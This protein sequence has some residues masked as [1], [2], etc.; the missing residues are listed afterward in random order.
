MRCVIAGG[1]TGGHLFPGIAIAEAFVEK[2]LGNEVL[3][4]GTEKGIEARVL[5]GGRFPLRMIQAKP[6]KGESFMAQMKSLWTLPRAIVQARSILGDFRPQVVLGVGGYAS[7]PALIAALLSGMKRTIHEQNVVP[8]MTN[9]LL[10]WISQRI[11]VSFEETKRYFPERKT[12]VTGTPVREDFS[13]R[14]SQRQTGKGVAEKG[15]R[16]TLLIFGG[17]AGAHRINVAMMDA[18][19]TLG[20][21][22]ASVRFIHQTGEAD[23]DF[24]SRGY[25]AHGFEAQV[26]PF[27]EDMASCYAISDL[28]VCRAGASTI[29]ELAI[30]GKAAVLVPYPHA[31]HQHQLMNAQQLVERGA[32]RLIRDEALNGG[33]IAETILELYDHPEKRVRMGQ[34]IQ[35]MSRPRAAQEIVEGC[36]R[37]IHSNPSASV[38]S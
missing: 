7:G 36:Y 12:V 6:L 2:E 5:A 14:L 28:V 20:E 18:L 8:G 35:E 32:A 16:F 23:F 17:S 26:K 13:S 21:K 38:G 1:G 37:L 34:A 22:K 25:Q 29:A 3:F 30:C 10:K 9:R 27:F 31:A 11:F 15:D 4:I 19:S 24:V 33:L